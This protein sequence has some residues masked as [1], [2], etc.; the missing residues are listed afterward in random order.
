M[1]GRWRA[2]DTLSFSL[3]YSALKARFVSGTLN[4]VSV[5]GNELPLVPSQRYNL[6]GI[7]EPLANHR[8]EVAYQQVSSQRYSGD[9]N[10]TLN[11]RI[12]AYA[13]WDMG[14]RFQFKDGDVGIA[15]R[16]L[17]D[18]RYFS[19]GFGP[20]GV[21]PEAGRTITADINLHF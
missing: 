7:W 8:I 20:G 17:T 2:L 1:E 10:N 3:H 11:D 18:H 13:L 12:S 4:G 16:N 5:E 6:R 15:A 21:Y 9:N 14:Y 19:V